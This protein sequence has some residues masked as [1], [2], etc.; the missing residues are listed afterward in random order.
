[1]IDWWNVEFGNNKF[2]RKGVVQK[3]MSYYLQIYW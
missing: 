3:D 2:G 1:M